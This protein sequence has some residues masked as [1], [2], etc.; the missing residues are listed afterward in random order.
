G[1]GLGVGVCRHR[2]QHV[3]LRRLAVAPNY[4]L[5]PTGAAGG[6]SGYHRSVPPRR[7]SGTFGHRR[8]VMKRKHLRW[9]V[10]LA[11]VIVLAGSCVAYCTWPGGGVPSGT[12]DV[13]DGA[14]EW[15]L[16]SLFPDER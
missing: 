4:P 11:L 6:D 7:V 8:G 12:W 10:P 15:E 13:L 2:G 14:D 5:H 3:G 16:F 1:M 9:V